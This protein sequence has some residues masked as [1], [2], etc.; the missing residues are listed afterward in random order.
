MEL[1][2]YYATGKVSRTGANLPGLAASRAGRCRSNPTSE[3]S[4]PLAPNI[5]VIV[6]SILGD[7]Y[8]GGSVLRRHVGGRRVEVRANRSRRQHREG[9]ARRR[10]I[11][12]E[13]H[14]QRARQLRIADDF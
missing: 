4:P 5:G 1:L 7:G 13:I 3:E 6:G 11:A 14:I 8:A 2:G 10:L 12:A 9:T